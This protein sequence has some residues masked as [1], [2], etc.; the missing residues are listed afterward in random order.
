MDRSQHLNEH[1]AGE[2][3]EWFVRLQDSRETESARGEFVDWLMRS[4][5][6]VEEFLGIA[7]TWGETGAVDCDEY[8]VEALT[9]A[10][11][12]Q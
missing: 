11:L 10:A 4:P 9:A 6:H 7:R 5:T 1:I 12:D 2:A 3:A 8:S